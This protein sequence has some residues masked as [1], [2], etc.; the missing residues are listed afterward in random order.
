MKR[1][2]IFMTSI[3]LGLGLLAAGL[4][5]RAGLPNPEAPR[6]INYYLRLDANEHLVELSHW[7]ALILGYELLDWFP[8]FFVDLKRLNPDQL[9][10]LYIDPVIVTDNPSGHPGHLEYDFFHG[11]DPSWY[12]YNEYGEVISYW[13]TSIHT[14]IT[15]HCPVVG[16][17]RFRDY[18]VRF[19]RERLYPYVENGTVDGIFLDEM[20]G[21]GYTWWDPLFDGTFDYNLDGIG[22][23]PDS[24][25]VW[26]IESMGMFADSL[27]HGKPEGCYVIGNNCKPRHGAL[28]GKFY[29]GF[30]A[31]WEGYLEGTLHDIDVWH[32]LAGP[33]EVTSVNGLYPTDDLR[34]FRHIYT[35]SLLTDN[36]FS[37]DHTT[38]DHHQLTWYDLFDYNLGL[39]LG[40]RYTLYEDPQ[41]TEE[42]ERGLSGHVHPTVH[43]TG[44]FTSNPDLVIQGEHSYLIHSDTDNQY[45]LLAKITIPGGW[46]AGSWY[47]V[48]FQFRSIAQQKYE[49]R[50]FMKGWSMSG[51][52]AAIVTSGE[53][54]LN[55]GAEGLFRVSFQLEDFSDYEI[56]LR[57]EWNMDLLIDSLTVVQGRGGLWAR[58][59]ENGTVICNES[60]LSQVI[61]FRA[62]WD[63][64]DGDMQREHYPQWEQ[65]LPVTLAFQDGL[66]FMLCDP[67]DVPD[68][69][70][71]PA[72]LRVDGP[73]PNPGNPAF[74]FVM[75]GREGAATELS[76]HSIDGR[77]LATLWKGP[78]PADG[79]QLDYR[80]GRAPLPELPSGVYLLRARSG[81]ELQTRK[82][83]LLR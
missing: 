6:T 5:A 16:G 39:P 55:E 65:N 25:E 18:F 50:I 21:G 82:W 61:P 1:N 46:Q 19:V 33:M 27:A 53:A 68:G 22:D 31:F 34:H 64:A 72:S 60:G 69:P 8:D 12:A 38:L 44:A 74:N 13:G 75:T 51:D 40:R 83:V 77:R 79:L 26:L 7:D 45:P 52:P 23:P 81:D 56:Y 47:T 32:S 37:F 80:S 30:P 67:V 48:S 70:V 73:W 76:L 9:V 36:Y 42:F 20:S 59:Y 4:D 78:M 63:L 11:V 43:A 15:R 58:D 14:N 29:E 35:A 2:G 17:E 41:I 54:K 28:D 49:G 3:L 62:D 71:S 57:S 10:Y 66:V 24:V